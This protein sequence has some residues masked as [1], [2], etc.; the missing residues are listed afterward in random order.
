MI[1][2]KDNIVFKEWFWQKHWTRRSILFFPVKYVC[3]FD[4]KDSG[5]KKIFFT[6]YVMEGDVL[7][8]SIKHIW[9]P[10]WQEFSKPLYGEDSFGIKWENCEFIRIGRW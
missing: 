7:Y 5:K 4:D 2:T 8:R 1:L 6:R 9:G 10:I 3:I